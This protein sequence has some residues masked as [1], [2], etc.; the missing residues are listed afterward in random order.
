MLE[1]WERDR[2]LEEAAVPL[3]DNGTALRSARTEKI[4]GGRR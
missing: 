3:L 2:N 4:P 1:L